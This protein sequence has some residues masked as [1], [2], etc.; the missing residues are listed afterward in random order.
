MMSFRNRGAQKEAEIR[1][2]LGKRAVVTETL[3][4]RGG[5][6]EVGELKL[7]ARLSTESPELSPGHTVMIISY[8]EKRAIVKPLNTCI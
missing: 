5:K 8:S 1:S 6:V 3:S 4:V 2:C 7:K